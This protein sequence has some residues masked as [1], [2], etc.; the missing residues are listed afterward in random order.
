[1]CVPH[2]EFLL[3]SAVNGPV[4][5]CLHASLFFV[6][7]VNWIFLYY[8][9]LTQETRF[10]TLPTA[11]LFFIYF[12]IEWCWYSCSV[13]FLN[14]FCKVCIFLSFMLWSVCTFSLC[15]AFNRNFLEHQ[16]REREEGN[17]QNKPC[18]SGLGYL[19]RVS[20]PLP[21]PSFLAFTEHRD[22]LE[23]KASS[24]LWSFQ[25]MHP[26]LDIHVTFEIPQCKSV[27]LNIAKKLSPQV[28]LTGSG[29]LL[30]TLTIIFCPEWLHVAYW[31]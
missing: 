1:M 26:I 4:I 15:S 12:F 19:V 10:F 16:K 29:A 28:I 27:A 30:Y 31:P 23:V 3:I 21:S 25:T 22:Q 9:V 2:R 17:R 7:V 5:C 8:N 18:H 11:F 14:N 6:V 13:T 24:L 20:T